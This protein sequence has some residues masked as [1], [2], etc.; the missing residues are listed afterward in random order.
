M[1]F[2]YSVLLPVML[3]N[4]II[5][6]LAA[7]VAAAIAHPNV[8]FVITDDQGYG[9]LSCHGNPILKTPELDKLHAESVRLTDYHVSPTCAPTRGALMSGH[10]TNRCGPWHTIMGRCFLFEGE[11]TLGDAFSGGGYATGMFGKWHLGDNYPFR[12]EDRGFQEVVRHGAGGVGQAADY[13]D[14]AYFDDTYFHN[15]VPKKYS[16]YCTDVYF[17]EAKRFIGESLDAEKP[18]FAYI[19]TNAPHGPYHC[20]DKYWKP[21]MEIL[22]DEKK[23]RPAIFFGM[24]ANIDENVGKMRAFLE[25]KGVADDTIFIFTTDNGTAG[26]EKIFNAGMS[27]KKGSNLEGG[28]RV[29]FFMHWPKGGLGEGRDLKTLSAHVDVLPTLTELCELPAIP[30]DYKLDGKSLVPLL[31]G[32]SAGKVGWPRR[33]LI[34]DSQRVKDPIKWRNSSTM[35]QRWRLINGKQL[36]DMKADPGQ[37]EDVAEKHPKVVARLRADYD[38]WWDGLEPSF[39]RF[40]RIQIGSKFENPTQL[41]SHDWLTDENMVPWNQYDIRAGAKRKGWWALNVAEAGKYRIT[42][43]RWPSSTDVAIVDGVEP[44]APVQ[45]LKSFRETPGAAIEV[46]KAKLEIGDFSGEQKVE[47]KASGVSFEME[48]AAGE[49][50]LKTTFFLKDGK[51]ISAYYAEVEKL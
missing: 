10:V 28:H 11:K 3:L 35:T 13:W 15:S 2:S 4:R 20:P 5:L 48:L 26:G 37:K 51:E 25:E 21:Y 24:I 23:M 49:T 43:R 46:T 18:F 16:G 42:L 7:S 19:S 41:T 45:G 50:E 44:G 38:A 29:P 14:N 39:K 30:D 1:D 36:Y 12:P 8:V 32:E 34:T 6:S 9:D 17:E 47:A 27:G 33:T 22:D 40:A 31:K